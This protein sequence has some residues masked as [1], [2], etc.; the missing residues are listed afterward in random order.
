MFKGVYDNYSMGITNSCIK[1]QKDAQVDERPLVPYKWI[2]HRGNI[3]GPDS[4]ENN[5]IYVNNTL[6]MGY[7]CEIDVR[8]ID[9]QLYM[10]HDHADYEIPLNY[11]LDNCNKLWIHCKNVEAMEFLLSYSCLNIFWH[12]E[13]DY[14]LTRKGFIWAYPGKKITQTSIILMPENSGLDTFIKDGYGVCSDYVVQLQGR[15]RGIK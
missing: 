10:G 6:K 15:N 11:L 12:Q 13:D 2:A 9:G 8:Y 4:R 14:T 7:D 1:I 5:P 3:M